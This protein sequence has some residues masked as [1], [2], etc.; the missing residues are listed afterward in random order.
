VVE[1]AA[2]LDVLA[3]KKRITPE[4]AGIGKEILL[5]I[6]SM[7]AGLIARFSGA[8]REDSAAY[9]EASTTLREN[10]NE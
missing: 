7:V 3:V 2:C 8:V 1:C 6:V 10:E 5:G 4:E 9:A